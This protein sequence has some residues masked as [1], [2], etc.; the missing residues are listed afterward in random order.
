MFGT[1]KLSL[2]RT[3]NRCYTWTPKLK[4]SN[5]NRTRPLLWTWGSVEAA[6]LYSRWDRGRQLRC[7]VNLGPMVNMLSELQNR[8]R[9]PGV[10]GH[11]QC[12]PELDHGN[13]PHGWC[14]GLR[15]CLDP[16]TVS[17]MNSMLLGSY[18]RL[19]EY[20]LQSPSCLR[21]RDHLESS[22]LVSKHHRIPF[23]WGPGG[24]Y[25]WKE[26]DHGTRAVREGGEWDFD[27]CGTRF[28]KMKSSMN[29]VMAPQQGECTW[30]FGKLHLKRWQ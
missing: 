27:G 16:D 13:I 15:K 23:K 12:P 8:K 6:F 3:K 18:P 1:H 14:G 25:S 7:G 10:P 19:S 22:W 29:S 28:Y 9:T 5:I 4:D 17:H 26:V 20:P 2:F 24:D 21:S 30:G 11:P